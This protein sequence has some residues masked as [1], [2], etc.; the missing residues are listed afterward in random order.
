MELLEYQL[1]DVRE[2]VKDYMERGRSHGYES[3]TE[4]QALRDLV[5]RVVEIVDPQAKVAHEL[6]RRYPV[7][8]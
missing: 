5:E 6:A 3:A 7:R 2:A 4:R 1:D 8:R